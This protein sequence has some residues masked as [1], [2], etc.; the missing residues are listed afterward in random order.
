MTTHRGGCHCGKI[1]YEF[2]GEIGEVV[3]CNCSYCAPRGS[4]LHFVPATGFRLSDPGD[5]L[6][7]YKFNKHMLDHHFCKVC[8]IGAFSEGKARGMVAINVRC[9]EGVDPLTL[10]KKFFNGRDL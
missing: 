6:A 2:D 9:V 5:A 3:E 4:L 7:T 1:A 8:G 10:K